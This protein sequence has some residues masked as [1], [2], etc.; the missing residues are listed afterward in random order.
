MGNNN[1]TIIPLIQSNSPFG[2]IERKISFRYLRSKK[3]QGGVGLISLISF[4]CIMLAIAAMIIIMSIMNGFRDEMINLTIGSEGHM[5][6]ASSNPDPNKQ[7]I[8]LLEKDLSSLSGIEGAF[9]FTQNFTGIQAN[10]QFGLAKVIGIA[11]ENLKDFSLVVSNI[12]EGSIQEFSS[13]LK[14][15]NMITIGSGLANSFGLKVGDSIVIYSPNSRQTISG[16]MPIK[17]SY[18]VGAIFKSGLYQADLS[19]IY[20]DINQTSLLF[21]KGLHSGEIQIRLS[22]PDELDKI[23]NE[24]L[25]IIDEPVFI[26]SWKDRNAS[27][28]TALRTEQIA[29]RFIFMVVVI[30]AVF[31]VLASMIMLVKNKSKDIAVLRTL[32]VSRAAIL[33]IFFIT[34]VS[35][36]SVGTFSGV[37]LGILFCS[38]VEHIQSVLE[39]ITGVELFPEDVYQLSGGIPSKVIWVEVFGVAF[40]GF[41]ISA[42]ATFFPALTASRIDPVDALRYD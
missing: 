31:P 23:R 1:E 7:Y 26:Q 25:N 12:I 19:N 21:N 27:T 9:Q 15:E 30:I 18:T 10:S 36:G 5:F 37:L 42:L 34:G 32:G 16:P 38:N 33:R 22:N 17:K 4:I 40:W 6:V 20:M 28:A 13:S 3:N 24:I 35:I 39:F 41:L 8:E 29:M 11:P 14:Q 2:A